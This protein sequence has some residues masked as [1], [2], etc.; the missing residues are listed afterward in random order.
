MAVASGATGA[1]FSDSKSGSIGGTLDT[2]N[3]STEGGTGADGLTFQWDNMLPGKQETARIVFTNSGDSPVD[4]YLWFWNETALSALNSLGTYG[5]VHISVN[6]VEKYAN[7]NLND[8]PNNGTEGMPA[9]ILL[10]SNLEPNGSGSAVFAFNYAAKL[11]GG[12]TNSSGVWVPSYSSG[13]GDFNT[14]PVQLA[15][16]KTQD[17][18]YPA[19]Y[20]QL[21]VIPGQSGSGLPFKVVATQ[22]GGSF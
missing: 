18:R 20:S 10:V 13:G 8:I 3:L 21:T 9:K 22:V 16:G 6:G 19:G 12:Y 17:A 1:Y 15:P 14:Y 11:G 5:E 7:A 4:V 2:I